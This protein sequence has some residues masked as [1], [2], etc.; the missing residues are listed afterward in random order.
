[1]NNKILV[2]CIAVIFITISGYAQN[3][4]GNITLFDNQNLY[5]GFMPQCLSANG[6]YVCGSSY[7][8]VGF[9][10]DW[11][12]QNTLVCNGREGNPFASSF[13]YITNE[14]KA[15]GGSLI[16]INT[17][18]SQRLGLG[19][20][21]DMMTE[22]GSIFVGMTPNKMYSDF[23]SPHNIEYQAC[24][25]ENGTKHLLP[26]P[27]EEELGYYYLRT[28]ARCISSD[29]SVIMGEIVDRLYLLPMILWHR[30]EDGNYELDA[31]CKDYF[32][33]IKYNEGYYKEYVRFQG[34]ALS[35]NGQWV[36]MI[37]R[38]APEYGRPADADDALALYNVKTGE[39]CKANI[40]DN[41]GAAPSPR[42]SIYYN[43]V[44]DDG[45]IV[46]YYNNN[47]GGESAFIMHRKD[48]TPVNFIDAFPTIGHFADFD[49]LGLN[50]V[51]SITPDGRYICGYGWQDD[52]IGYV[53]DTATTD[54][55]YNAEEASVEYVQPA[56]SDGTTEYYDISGR[57]L[58]GPLKGINIVRHSGGR[59]EK[60]IY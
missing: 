16:D 55:S 45:T 35:K 44:S 46:G 23:G 39:L 9:V 21:V 60:V 30:Q 26:V 4:E 24:Y 51:S 12:E 1:M 3:T 6:R 14:G 5:G 33:D 59:T 2:S 22:D 36:A 10:S 58:D 7:S 37:L 56:D 48:M 11:Q 25:W 40:T 34:C 29:G 18:E 54:E 52:Y 32:S 8:Q 17:G 38:D 42:Y 47:F 50:R 53:F 41:L 27:S 15:L 20:Y 49:E 57:R 13:V 43:G 19:G 28:R 31:V